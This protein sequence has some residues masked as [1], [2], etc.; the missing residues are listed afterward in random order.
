MGTFSRTIRRKIARTAME[1]EGVKQIN[2]KKYDKE[3]KETYSFFSKNWRAFSP[4]K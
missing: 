3:T 1:T 2:K 4:A